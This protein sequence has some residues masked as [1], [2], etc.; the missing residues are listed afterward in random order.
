MLVGSKESIIG[1]IL[2]SKDIVFTFRS[3]LTH[4]SVIRRI[5]CASMLVST[6]SLG[7]ECL[8]TYL[9]P[10][11]SSVSSQRLCRSQ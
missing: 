10:W 6:I 2:L 5:H 7:Q 1:M 11:G 3:S 8:D 9:S 4:Y